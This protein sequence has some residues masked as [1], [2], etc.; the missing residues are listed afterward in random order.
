MIVNTWKDFSGSVA[1][2]ADCWRCFEWFSTLSSRDV[3]KVGAWLRIG[4]E[5]AVNG[6]SIVIGGEPLM[7]M[8]VY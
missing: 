1:V 3:A 8:T 5:N 6:G 4:D 2:V 7:M